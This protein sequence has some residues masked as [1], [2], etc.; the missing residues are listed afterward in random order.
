MVIKSQKGSALVLALLIGF[1]GTIIG[2]TLYTVSSAN[3]KQVQERTNQLQADYYAKSGVNLALGI[4]KNNL[5]D[6]NGDYLTDEEEPAEYWG[7]LDGL[8]DREPS[9]ESYT[10][11]LKI[12]YESEYDCYSIESTGYVRGSGVSAAQSQSTVR[13]KISRKTIIDAIGGDPSEPG[14]EDTPQYPALDKIFAVGVN[15]SGKAIELKGQPMGHSFISG[16]TAVNSI[17]EKSVSFSYLTST[18]YGDLYIGPGGVPQKVVSFPGLWQSMYLPNGSIKNLS[19]IQIFPLPTFPDAQFSSPTYSSIE[20]QHHIAT[21]NT[22]GKYKEIVVEKNDTLFINVN[23]QDVIL[24]TEDFKVEGNIIINRNGTGK[25]KLFVTDELNLQENGN[26]QN[27]FDN[28]LNNIFNNI[29]NLMSK[30]IDEHYFKKIDELYRKGIK[31]LGLNGTINA[32]GNPDWLELYYSGE[33]ELKFNNRT[34]FF[35]SVYAQMADI[36][37]KNHCLIAGNIICGGSKVDLEE[38][39]RLV[40][41]A[42]EASLELASGATILGRVVARDIT[43][44]SNSGIIYL[45]LINTDF[46]KQLEWNLPDNSDDEEDNPPVNN[47]NIIQ[48]G[49]W[50]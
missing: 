12:I 8:S 24:Q 26:S 32:F 16:N 29:N 48:L 25:V 13:Y 2:T 34:I 44:K 41:Y 49:K 23:N 31:E 10:I 17:A 43:L 37:I 1:L 15:P 4:I 6:K 46:F 19:A 30:E 42:P 18:L 45:N 9:D 28:I 22:S 40:I 33:D 35:G 14:D 7:T 39:A 50:Y 47:I 20:Y 11:E 38:C 3:A 21:I 27:I 5:A 36:T